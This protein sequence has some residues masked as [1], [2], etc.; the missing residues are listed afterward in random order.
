MNKIIILLLV[1]LFNIFLSNN[2][3]CNWSPVDGSSLKQPRTMQLINNK[4]IFIENETISI[5]IEKESAFVSVLYKL[6][7]TINKQDVNVSFPVEY[8]LEPYFDEFN[9]SNKVDY[10]NAYEKSADNYQK[11]VCNE[12]SIT[13]NFNKDRDEYNITRWYNAKLNFVKNELK[14]IKVEYKM[15]LGFGD[16]ISTIDYFVRYSPRTFKYLLTPAKNWGNGL[17]KHIEINMDLNDLKTNNLILNNIKFPGSKNKFGIFQGLINIISPNKTLINNKYYYSF[18]SDNFNF[19]NAENIELEFDV[20]SI[21][22]SQ[23]ALSNRISN[24]QIISMKSSSTLID[25]KYSY[26]VSNLIDNN[27]ST[28]WVEGSSGQGIGDWVEFT[29]DNPKIG[30]IGIING[31]FINEK[32]YYANSRIKKLNYYVEYNTNYNDP[33]NITFQQQYLTYHTNNYES[34]DI[35]FEDK[36]YF[37]ISKSNFYRVLERVYENPD[38][39]FPIKKFRLTIKDVYPGKSYKD[40]CISEIYFLSN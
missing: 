38:S 39:P 15:S 7:N 8:L 13:N 6:K 29:F 40:T 20:G 30:Y 4:S 35:N 25:K 10:F 32:L 14:E 18:K 5:K 21:Y 12:L 24:N 1:I 9:N 36:P 3:Y 17:A 31:L 23:I 26:S 28:A 11:I 22:N 2:L 16:G 33:N 37:N 27:F 34:Y 19:N